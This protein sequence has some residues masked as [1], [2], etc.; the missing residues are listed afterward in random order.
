MG[1]SHDLVRSMSIYFGD[2]HGF[3]RFPLQNNPN[4]QGFPKGFPSDFRVISQACPRPRTCHGFSLRD[5]HGFLGSKVNELAS[6]ISV[7]EFDMTAAEAK[8]HEK[9]GAWT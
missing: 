8:K 9:K 4:F 2:F 6:D 3:P 1:K 7:F 5:F